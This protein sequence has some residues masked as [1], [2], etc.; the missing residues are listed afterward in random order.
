[1]GGWEGDGRKEGGRK[2]EMS[3]EGGRERGAWVC[4]VALGMWEGGREGW[5]E[6]RLEGGKVRGRKGGRE[7]RKRARRKEGRGSI[8]T[9][10][11]GT[12]CS[13][14]GYSFAVS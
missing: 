1:M 6:R 3:R 9:Q 14:G 4:V 11:W 10:R 8:V 12:A 13:T 5:R 7:W 2:D